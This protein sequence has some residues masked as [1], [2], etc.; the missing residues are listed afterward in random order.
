[1]IH[2]NI[3][4]IFEREELILDNNI[5]E[6][7]TA[8]TSIR[9]DKNDS[10]A[11]KKQKQTAL[12]KFNSKI[13]AQEDDKKKLKQKLK[14]LEEISTKEEKPYFLWHLFFRDIF[15]G[16]SGG[17]DIVIG[18]PP[19]GVDVDK[20][21]QE[22]YDLGKRDSYG[23]FMSMALK[24]LMKPGGHLCYIVS[25][26]WLTISSHFKLRQQILD[27]HHL[28][29][30]IR[31]HGDCFKA[32]VNS[33]IVTV[34]AAS[35][36]TN[37]TSK[38]HSTPLSSGEGPGVRSVLAA[39]LT[40]LS[41]RKNVAEFRDKLFHLEEY[42]GTSTPQFAVYEYEQDLLEISN[43]QPVIVGSPKLFW[44]M[45]EFDC[46]KET[47]TI[48][49]GEQAKEVEVRKIPFNGKT[50]ELVPFGD[51][52]DVKVGLQTGDNDYYLYQNPEVRGNYKN[53]NDYKQYLLTE[54]DLEKIRGNA[55]VR[56]KVIELGIHQSN[57][58]KDFDKDRWF[59]GRYIV[60]YDK[61]GE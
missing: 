38:V 39:D 43:N 1:I 18:N 21:I 53:I 58:E 8:K 49:E 35:Q 32:T 34:Q 23:V 44:L 10:T 4:S 29:K 51:I 24:K 41:T 20:S 36:N 5:Q 46:E 37:T 7:E 47:R 27:H 30:V 14:R 60:P 55:E 11:K 31:L 54:S 26:T 28:Q 16:S 13:K 19:Y 59:E 22:L 12:D 33:C 3:V 45:D 17:F 57:K 25:D 15:T 56:K 52:A 9:L 50:V 2:E 48:G 6:A 40:N 61:G 42:V